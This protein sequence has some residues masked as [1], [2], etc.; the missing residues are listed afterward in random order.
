METEAGSDWQFATQLLWHRLGA[1]A[2][3]SSE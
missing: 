2:R 3:D 1:Y